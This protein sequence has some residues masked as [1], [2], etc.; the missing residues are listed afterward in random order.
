MNFS[1]QQFYDGELKA[2]DSVKDRLLTD[3]EDV[4]KTEETESPLYFI[5]TTGKDFQESSDQNSK[6]M[7]DSKL[8]QGEADLVV[9][10]VNYLI[11][12]GVKDDDIAIISPYNAQVNL[13]KLLLKDAHPKLEI[14]TVDG[15]QG[16]EKQVV[17]LTLVRSNDRFEIGFLSESRRLNVAL[18]RA[19]SHL[20]LICD[21]EFLSASKD[22]VLKKM[23]E[24]FEEHALIAYP[25]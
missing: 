21:G 14:G 13:L 9:K 10:H 19:K 25:D 17:I 11:S 1:S 3:S 23:V 15:F 7:D 12:Q 2:H 16:R 18:T 24:Y 5:D 4:I 20:V 6:Y 8:N 22:K